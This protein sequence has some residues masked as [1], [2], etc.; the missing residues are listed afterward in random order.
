MLHRK[1]L[2]PPSSHPPPLAV[3]CA[4]VALGRI[5]QP[6]MTAWRRPAPSSQS[7]HREDWNMN[8]PTPASSPSRWCSAAISV[9]A[10]LATVLALVSPAF[11]DEVHQGLPQDKARYPL[12]TTFS[13]LPCVV[14]DV[15]PKP[16][17]TA[18]QVY[19][20]KWAI[21][22]V[23]GVPNAQTTNFK[24]GWLPQPFEWQTA[25]PPPDASETIW[26]ADEPGT[27]QFNSSS[28][29]A[30]WIFDRD[31]QICPF[32]PR[33]C[34]QPRH[35]DESF[36]GQG[37]T[38]RG[39]FEIY[40]PCSLKV[41]KIVKQATI[42]RRST[43]GHPLEWERLHAGDVIHHGD[44]VRTAPG[45]ELVLQ[46]ATVRHTFKGGSQ[47][48]F[49]ATPPGTCSKEENS[50]LYL[51]VGSEILEFFEKKTGQSPAVETEE[52][53][54]TP[55]TPA[56]PGAPPSGIRAS[57]AKRWMVTRSPRQHET[58]STA[59]TVRIRVTSRRRH[60]TLIARPGQRVVGGS[61]G[62]RLVR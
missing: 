24:C 35:W 14:S 54:T 15:A 42:R 33:E 37:P 26:L 17:W 48:H 55:V 57:T 3:C 53:V 61:K 9:V 31:G 21:T 47:W 49:T 4:R 16:P 46:G 10:V 1:A 45:G 43:P 52:T 19:S 58:V 40:D 29:R 62:I 23:W 2:R 11:G 30:D 18:G 25:V 8:R 27:Y 28:G 39:S 12:H 38:L 44:D 50:K 5:D 22:T 59:L 36:I 6:G 34:S 41:V 13:G 20:Q 7:E 32:V 60:Q 56:E 51:R